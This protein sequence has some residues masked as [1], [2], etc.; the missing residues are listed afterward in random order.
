MGFKKNLKSYLDETE[1]GSFTAKIKIRKDELNYE[2]DDKLVKNI[3]WLIF[4]K[5][6]ACVTLKPEKNEVFMIGM[7]KFNINKYQSKNKIDFQEVIDLYLEEGDDIDINE[8]SIVAMVSQQMSMF[9]EIFWLRFGCKEFGITWDK[10]TRTVSLGLGVDY[11]KSEWAM[12]NKSVTLHKTNPD[13]IFW[14]RDWAKD[15]DLDT[16]K[17]GAKSG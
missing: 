15:E 10:K 16:K 12:V 4:T 13:G 3:A 7:N 5:G 6:N 17:G 2:A 1:D 14:K 11:K 9:V 8:N